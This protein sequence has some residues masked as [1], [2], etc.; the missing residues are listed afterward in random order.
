MIY[1]SYDWDMLAGTANGR[2]VIN[3]E[4]FVPGGRCMVAKVRLRL[5]TKHFSGIDAEDG[6][7]GVLS[8][9]IILIPEESLRDT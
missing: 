6:L 8:S 5:L 9:Q 7:E 2:A 1:V 3:D 4:W